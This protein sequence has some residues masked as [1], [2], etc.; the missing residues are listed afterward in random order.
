MLSAE[1][2][3]G[4]DPALTVATM[5]RIAARAEQFE[6]LQASSYERGLAHRRAPSTRAVT[7]AMAHAAQRAADE[8]RLAAIVCCTREGPTARAMAALRP[9][10]RLIGASP[11]AR[12][13]RQLT[14]S[15]G[16]EPLV[17]DEYDTT[18]EMVWC[19]VEATVNGGLVRHGDA[20]AVLAGAP[21]ASPRT[22]DV[23]RVVQVD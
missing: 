14:L 13:A 5:A 3:I 10:C 2:A 1:T 7:V 22:T 23:L 17:V 18:D 9:N 6:D 11:S 4:H 20:I 15:W 8:L 21:H 12:T 19:V 16:V